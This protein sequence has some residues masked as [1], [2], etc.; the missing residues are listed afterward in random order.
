MARFLGPG[1]DAGRY[2]VWW[3]RMRS[4]EPF[5]GGV[6]TGQDPSRRARHIPDGHVATA[7]HAR[8][9]EGAATVSGWQAVRQ[10]AFVAVAHDHPRSPPQG[11]VPGTPGTIIGYFSLKRPFFFAYTSGIRPSYRAV[12]V[13]I[14]GDKR[15]FLGVPA[16]EPLPPQPG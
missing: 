2:V 1:S 9:P 6:P 8:A 13:G 7:T 11:A 15:L 10:P 12:H 4:S 16:G 14:I 5:F 3:C